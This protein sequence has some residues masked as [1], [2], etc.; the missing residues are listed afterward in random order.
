[1][2]KKKIYTQIMLTGV[3]FS[4]L[5]WLLD[6]LRDEF[7]SGSK[8]FFKYLLP[9]DSITIWIRLLGV[10]VIILSSS[11]ISIIVMKKEKEAAKHYKKRKSDQYVKALRDAIPG[12]LNRNV[13]INMLTMREKVDKFVVDSEKSLSP[14]NIK[15]L[16]EIRESFEK[17]IMPIE[18]LADFSA[19]AAGY[20][21]LKRSVFNM[22]QVVM[23]SLDASNGFLKEK[24]LSVDKSFSDDEI[25]VYAD[26]DKI[27]NTI[28]EILGFCVYY[29]DQNDKLLVNVV[30]TESDIIFTIAGKF[31]DFSRGAFNRVF[32]NGQASMGEMSNEEILSMVIARASILSHKGRIWL[33]RNRN[34][35]TSINF[36][37]TKEPVPSVMIIDDDLNTVMLVKDVL[38]RDKYRVIGKTDGEDALRVLE[39]EKPDLIIL[40]L[41]MPGIDGYEF[42]EKVK[43]QFNSR[44]IPLIIISGFHLDRNILMEVTG[45]QTIMPY[46]RKPVD[47]HELRKNVQETLSK[48]DKPEWNQLFIT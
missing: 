12:I 9:G 13:K 5:Y 20:F 14:G 19:I 28:I 4:M 23:Q 39:D 21:S 32:I 1:M 31:H 2:K 33:S 8:Y 47:I 40:D 41:M 22:N 35:N 46:I 10:F 45:G 17:I 15:K 42:I 25:F 18:K 48:T 36:S 24:N 43:N 29:S 44:H 34:N 11:M 26:S 38:E 37:I 30:D 3:F 6:T 27:K 16:L 7:L